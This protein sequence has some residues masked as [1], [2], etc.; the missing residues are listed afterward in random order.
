MS[1]LIRQM[2]EK[3]LEI[4]SEILTKRYYTRAIWKFYQCYSLALALL[5]QQTNLKIDRKRNRLWK[6]ILL[7]K[8][9]N[10]KKFKK[11]QEFMQ[12]DM[13]IISRGVN[14]LEDQK[15]LGYETGDIYKPGMIGVLSY[16]L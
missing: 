11:I 2:F 4:Y 7:S 10:E 6:K 16:Q 9:I 8:K 15:A 1:K 13:I 3:N 12:N 5:E 14:Y